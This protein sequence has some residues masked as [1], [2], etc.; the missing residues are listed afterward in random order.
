MPARLAAVVIA[1]VGITVAGV[2]APAGA[3]QRTVVDRVLP[4]MKFTGVTLGDALDCVRAV[5]AL[6]IHV[7]WKAL[8]EQN[9]APDTP[10]NIR[11]R[12]VTVRKLLN[13]LPSE[14]G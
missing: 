12:S 2:T 10:V 3:A 6:N 14:A 13:M 1:T 8:E 9:V 4:E 7:N 11:L 5:S